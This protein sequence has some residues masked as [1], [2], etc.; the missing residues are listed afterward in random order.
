MLTNEEEGQW[1]VMVTAGGANGGRRGGWDEEK[2]DGGIRG[3]RQIERWC[4]R[5]N[6]L[7]KFRV[8][9]SYHGTPLNIDKKLLVNQGS[10]TT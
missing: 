1:Q 10:P 3:L 7:I 4:C 8:M 2:G 6:F 5:N 9:D